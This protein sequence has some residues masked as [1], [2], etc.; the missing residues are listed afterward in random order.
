MVGACCAAYSN[1]RTSSSTL[2][3]A[4]PLSSQPLGC[5]AA[6]GGGAIDGISN[7]STLWNCIELNEKF[8]K[9]RKYCGILLPSDFL[10][11]LHGATQ[12]VRSVTATQAHVDSVVDRLSVGLGGC[13]GRAAH[14]VLELC[15]GYDSRVRHL[16][17]GFEASQ[18]MWSCA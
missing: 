2:L 11:V 9:R 8:G 10:H 18:L 3:N 15:I 6:P 16:N 7:M 5:G 1:S 17:L 14:V 12:E 13:S 4:L